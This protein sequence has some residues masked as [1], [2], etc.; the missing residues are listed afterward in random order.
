MHPTAGK[1]DL[2]ESGVVVSVGP[3]AAVVASMEPETAGV[4]SVGP[5][6]AVGVG[7]TIAE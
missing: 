6:T 5:G 3:A 2:E 7:S 4:A 1:G